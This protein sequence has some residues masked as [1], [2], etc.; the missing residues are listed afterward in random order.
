MGIETHYNTI[1]SIQRLAPDIA[2][3]TESYQSHI[4][5]VPCHIQPLD[6]SFSSDLE[7]SFG[8]N[9]LMFCAVAD[10][11]EADDVVVGSE[12][13]RVIGVDSYSFLGG[14]KHME[15]TIRKFIK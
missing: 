10:I 1:A 4:A 14:P 7:G 5:S 2:G 6:D 13:Y 9:F 15:L 12:T 11:L 8:K 3:E